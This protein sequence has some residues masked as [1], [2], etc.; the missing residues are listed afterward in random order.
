[1]AASITAQEAAREIYEALLRG[2]E[3][4][5]EHLAANGPSPELERRLAA[6]E[7]LAACSIYAEEYRQQKRRRLH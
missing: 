1:M 2:V 5:R 4:I 7:R 6:L 3:A